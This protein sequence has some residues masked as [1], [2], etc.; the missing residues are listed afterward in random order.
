[1]ANTK[2]FLLRNLKK[3]LRLLLGFYLHKYLKSRQL[4]Y[5]IKHSSYK[6]QLTTLLTTSFICSKNFSA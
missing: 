5:V 3:K 4:L 1:M 6:L 2:Y